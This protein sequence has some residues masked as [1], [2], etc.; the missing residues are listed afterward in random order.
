MFDTFFCEIVTS[1]CPKTP[2]SHDIAISLS[3][4][5]SLLRHILG[6]TQNGE[7]K[8]C[9]S[10]ARSL[11]S[12][13][14]MTSPYPWLRHS[15]SSTEIGE[16]IIWR[17]QQCGDVKAMA[18]SCAPENAIQKSCFSK[19]NK[20]SLSL[21]NYLLKRGFLFSK[22][23]KIIFFGYGGIWRDYP[24]IFCTISISCPYLNRKIFPYHIYPYLRYG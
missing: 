3:S 18:K 4:P 19:F 11:A 12:D 20:N 23:S 24:N 8:I 2:G 15:L 13:D 22:I 9:R 6:S 7:P 16:P 17:S 5:H 14:R 1:L 10:H 21:Y